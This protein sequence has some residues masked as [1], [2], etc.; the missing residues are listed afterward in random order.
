MSPTRR[1]LLGV[2]VLAMAAPAMAQTAPARYRASVAALEGDTLSL[3]TRGGETLKAALTPGTAITAVVPATLQD[4]KPGSFIG[5]A[6]LP[7]PNGTLVAIEVHVFP[8]NMRGVGEGHR[9][10]DLQPESTMTN[11]TV[12][13]V[14]GA[15]A[16]TLKVSYQGGEK[17]VLVPEQTPIVAFAPGGRDLLTRD[18]HIILFASKAAD[19]GLTAQRVLVGKDGLVPPM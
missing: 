17:I 13:S 7:G 16:R 4:I 1:T 3:V 10:F 18:A 15:E 19:G 11:G 5:T 12:G 6:A 14:V 2:L 9:P 8:E